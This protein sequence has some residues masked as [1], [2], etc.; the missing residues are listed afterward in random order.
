MNLD[1]I[2]IT[3]LKLSTAFEI[4]LEFDSR[5]KAESALAKIKTVL[6]IATPSDSAKAENAP[7]CPPGDGW[8]EYDDYEQPVPDDTMVDVLL[9]HERNNPRVYFEGICAA[10]AYNW[11]LSRNAR[12]SCGAEIVAYRVVR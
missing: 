2:K 5:E 11:G 8:V 6:S 4:K 12:E 9:L 7:W 3:P 1:A 10:S